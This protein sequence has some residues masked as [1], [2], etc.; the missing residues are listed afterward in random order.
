MS[1]HLWD[2]RPAL[3]FMYTYNYFHWQ[4]ECKYTSAMFNIEKASKR[5]LYLLQLYELCPD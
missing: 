1:Q 2:F 3:H 4:G 5:E